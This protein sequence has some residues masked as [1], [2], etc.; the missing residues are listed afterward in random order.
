MQSAHSTRLWVLLSGLEYLSSG[1][2]QCNLSLHELKDV[3]GVSDST[4]KN[5]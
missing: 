5:D 2:L 1:T 3:F 4:A